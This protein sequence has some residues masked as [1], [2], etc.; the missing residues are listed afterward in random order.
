VTVLTL[1]TRPGCHLCD[2]ARD[3]VL[4]RRAALPPFD[5]Q[6]VDIEADEALHAR[7]LERIPVFEVDGQVVSELHLDLAR[8]RARLDTVRQ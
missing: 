6:E 4:A 3:A 1:Y 2:E 7:Y 8:L 5:L